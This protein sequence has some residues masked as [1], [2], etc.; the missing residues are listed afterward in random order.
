MSLYVATSVNAGSEQRER[1]GLI[2]QRCG[3]TLIS[4][5][6]GRALN[7]LSPAD[8]PYLVGR[9][10]DE[11]RAGGASLFVNQGMLKSRLHSGVRHP[12][13]QA[14]SAG[15][16]L[17]HVI[18]GTL[19]L[20]GDGLHIAGALSCQVTGVEASPAL[21]SLLEEGLARLGTESGPAADCASAI[22]LVF[23]DCAQ[24]MADMP[25]NS[26]DAVLL[27]PMYAKPD[28]AAPGF[29]LLRSVADHCPLTHE[30]LDQALR[31]SGRVVVKW[32]RGAPMPAALSSFGGVDCVEGKR[33][34]YWVISAP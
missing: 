18:D 13:I 21:Y 30:Q 24:L 33:V 1:A 11:L 31:V 7:Q 5:T 32:P 9:A 20:A 14:L 19:G 27:A 17:R 34:N 10:R 6:G 15:L 3:G 2:A 29:E 25:A 8:T 22:R 12:L 26:A 4:A 23:G 28:K 16:P